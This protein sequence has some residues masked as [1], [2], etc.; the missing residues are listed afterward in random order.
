M[1]KFHSALVRIKSAIISAILLI[2]FYYLDYLHVGMMQVANRSANQSY[3]QLQY[4][5]PYV[6]FL[7]PSVVL[8][9]R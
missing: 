2:D 5:A 1:R 8:H 9:L 3:Q 6:Y 4:V 7:L